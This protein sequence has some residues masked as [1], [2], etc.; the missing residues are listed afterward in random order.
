MEKTAAEA[1]QIAGNELNV[2]GITFRPAY[3][4]PPYSGPMTRTLWVQLK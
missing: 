3:M 4:M 1:V 2:N